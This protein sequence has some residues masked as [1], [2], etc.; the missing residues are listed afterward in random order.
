MT[1][2]T[3]GQLVSAFNA[4]KDLTNLVIA[5]LQHWRKY[6]NGA[7]GVTIPSKS[8]MVDFVD[9][10]ET[11]IKVR[12]VYTQTDTF[13]VPYYYDVDDERHSESWGADN[14][15]GYTTGSISSPKETFINVPYT[16]LLASEEQMITE[17][18]NSAIRYKNK[19]QEDQRLAEIATLKQRLAKL[20]QTG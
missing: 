12:L 18:K 16:L 2:R 11:L 9:I 5:F 15:A 20:E 19:Q 13:S 8:F 7:Y 3:V 1:F 10:T 4:S 6:A 14:T 17:C